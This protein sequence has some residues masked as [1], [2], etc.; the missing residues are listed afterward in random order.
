M[1]GTESKRPSGRT[2]GSPGRADSMM[3]GYIHLL[4]GAVLCPAWQNPRKGQ[5][6][7]QENAQFFSRAVLLLKQEPETSFQF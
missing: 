6:T 2:A 5:V 4:P 3:L 7:R 1:E